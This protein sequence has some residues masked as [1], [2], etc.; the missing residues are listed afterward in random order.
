[1][2]KQTENQTRLISLQKSGVAVGSANTVNFTGGVESVSVSGDV[3]TITISTSNAV[4][5]IGSSTAYFH[6]NDGSQ[7]ANNQHDKDNGVVFY[8]T[9]SK[10]GEELVSC[11]LCSITCWYMEQW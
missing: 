1:M 3:A 8:G 4:T 7:L 2:T 11:T 10:K 9:K 6:L 5:A